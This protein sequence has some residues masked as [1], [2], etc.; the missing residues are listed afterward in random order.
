MWLGAGFWGGRPGPAWG[1]RWRWKPAAKALIAGF[2]TQLALDAFEIFGWLKNCNLP[3][4]P[5][6]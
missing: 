6:F 3:M 5:G 2:Q 4:I 1:G